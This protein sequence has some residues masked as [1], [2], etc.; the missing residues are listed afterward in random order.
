MGAN[1]CAFAG[2]VFQGEAKAGKSC[3]GGG[4]MRFVLCCGAQPEHE[5][6]A[7]RKPNRPVSGLAVH[8]AFAR[9]R[10]ESHRAEGPG[11]VRDL[12][13]S[14]HRPGQSLRRLREKKRGGMANRSRDVPVE[15]KNDECLK[16]I[17]P[18]I[19]TNRSVRRSTSKP[20]RSEEHTSEL[21]S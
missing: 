13:G 21:Q 2:V 4:A 8:R 12:G 5:V 10:W 1:I 16:A 7:E 18:V 11:A 3:R 9:R 14:A 6:S 17:N 15:R 19:P 20:A